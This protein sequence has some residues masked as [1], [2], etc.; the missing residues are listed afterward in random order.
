MANLATAPLAHATTT[1]R[2]KLLPCSRESR[3][4]ALFPCCPERASSPV[5]AATGLAR[6]APTSGLPPPKPATEIA[7]P[8][9]TDSPRPNPACPATPERRR[10]GTVPLP[11]AARRGTA[12]TDH[13]LA[14]QGHLQV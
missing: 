8:P 1:H 6:R 13:L 2:T 5:M 10:S 14:L 4:P 11:P 3:A 7:S 9:P 12:T